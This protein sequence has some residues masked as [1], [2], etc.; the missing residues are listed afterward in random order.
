MLKLMTFRQF[1]THQARP[2]PLEQVQQPSDPNCFKDLD[3]EAIVM[4]TISPHKSGRV[5][6]QGSYWFARCEQ[7]TMILPGTLVYVKGIYSITLLV[8]PAYLSQTD[9]Y[10]S[11]HSVVMLEGD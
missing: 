10:L 3:R 8:E 1:L 6:F 9:Y 5:S 4:T 11:E 7:N 2:A